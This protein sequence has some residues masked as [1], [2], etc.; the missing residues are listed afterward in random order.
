MLWRSVQSHSEVRC[1]DIALP[2][3]LRRKR[4]AGRYISMEEYRVALKDA[5][6][7]LI[8]LQKAIHRRTFLLIAAGAGGMG[9]NL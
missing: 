3:K 5:N 7:L 1:L 2:K 6:K 9:L 4:N 8:S